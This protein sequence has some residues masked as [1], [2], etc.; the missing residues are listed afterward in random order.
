[1]SKVGYVFLLL[2]MSMLTTKANAFWFTIPK[3]QDS[4]NYLGRA[5]QQTH[6]ALNPKHIDILVWNIY[7]GGLFGWEVDLER[8]SKNRDLVLLQEGILNQYMKPVLE[9]G[10]EHQ[11][12]FAT[13]FTYR[14]SKKPTGVLTGANIQASTFEYQRS[15]GRETIGYSPKMALFT[16]Y[17]I[18]NHAQELLAINIHALNTVSW[19]K[20]G[21]QILTALKIA[22]EHQGPVIFAGDF[23]SWSKKK[24]DFLFRTM[25]RAGFDNVKFEN[26]QERMLVY[27][28]PVDYIFTRG[29]ITKKARVLSEATGSDHKPLQATFALKL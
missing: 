12:I 10:R 25:E 18:Y 15:E 27:N 2:V 23:N 1:M 11:Y 16:Y 8:Y 19:K 6:S 28:Y 17:P 7:K 29:L 3:D 4:I 20:M 5:E 26:G 14:R 24:T 22:K 9:S 13:S 21:A